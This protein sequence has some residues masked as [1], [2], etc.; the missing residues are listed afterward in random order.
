MRKT[1][2][3]P[4]VHPAELKLSAARPVEDVPLPSEV[5]LPLSQHI[6]APAKPLVKP[7]QTVRRGQLLAEPMGFVSVGVHASVSGTV[8]K[9][10]DVM[11]PSGVPQKAIRIITDPDAD[12][13][14]CPDL[15]EPLDIDLDATKLHVDQRRAIIDRV[16]S[17]GVAGMGGAA[18]PTHVKL[19]PP[20]DVY[21]DR[22]LLNGAECEPYLTADHRLMVEHAAEV[23]D[24][25][26]ILLTLFP[27]AEGIIGVEDN[28]PD[29]YRALCAAAKGYKR[30]RVDLLKTKYPQGG[31]KQ[32]IW[33]LTGR[34][35]PSGNLPMTVGCVVQNV[36]TMASV[37]AAILEGRPMTDRIVTVTGDAVAQ[38]RNLRVRIGTPYRHLVEACGGIK[39]ELRKVVS[40]GPM[41]GRAQVSLDLPVLKGT[42]GLLLLSPKAA[43]PQPE[44]P[45][46]RCAA[47]L[48]ACPVSLEPT[49][50]A[51]LVSVERW[52]ELGEYGLMDC[53]ECGSCSYVCPAARYL[54]HRIRLGKSYVRRR[55]RRAKATK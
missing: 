19:S 34:Q 55:A 28:K 13:E 46:I 53:I 48:R 1:F 4:G 29:A 25:L 3:R 51:D 16:R 20:P 30:V 42:S 8:K 26:R 23:V 44:G 47:C 52:D 22:V 2:P 37:R 5:M 54:V 9:I 38:P 24:G 40:G 50:L 10:L 15:P 21:I 12:D 17:C 6:G 49:Q 27:G 7:R 18:F 45:C 39:G 43:D 31:E 36:A 35:V 41:M 11:H 32:L 14:W 33:A